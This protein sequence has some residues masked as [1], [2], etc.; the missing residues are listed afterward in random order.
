MRKYI[1]TVTAVLVG[2]TA[3]LGFNYLRP[4]EEVN[5]KKERY[6]SDALIQELKDAGISE[7]S[8]SKTRC[9]GYTSVSI[10]NGRCTVRIYSK[11]REAKKYWYNLDDDYRNL[12][13]SDFYTAVGT[14][15]GVCDVSIEDWIH[16]DKNVIVRVRQCQV[17]GWDTYIDENGDK[18]YMDGTLVSSV[19]PADEQRADAYEFE[20]L[21]LKCLDNL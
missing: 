14:E 17:S 6:T 9:D 19:T 21:I 3:L 16:L 12:K 11:T 18:R 15:L 13:Y 4:K 2:L 5:Y 20:E 10:G 8:I 1:V 7:Q